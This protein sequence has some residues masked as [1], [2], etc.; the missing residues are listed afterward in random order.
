MTV[1]EQGTILHL[2][3]GDDI[4][5]YKVQRY[6][7]QEDGS[8]VEDGLAKATKDPLYQDTTAK[9]GVA[10]R[11]EVTVRHGYVYDTEHPV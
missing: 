2:P 6:V 1:N 7:K 4:T 5:Q 10:Y 11:Y 9:E 8:Y 3:E